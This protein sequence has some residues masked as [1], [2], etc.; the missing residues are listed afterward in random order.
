VLQ[1]PVVMEV[2]VAAGLVDLGVKHVGG[3]RRAAGAAAPAAAVARANGPAAAAAAGA[4]CRGGRLLGRRVC[5]RCRAGKRSGFYGCRNSELTAKHIAHA[6]ARPCTAAS[7]PGRTTAACI[8]P[9]DPPPTCAVACS[10]AAAKSHAA[11]PELYRSANTR[12]PLL[13]DT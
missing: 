8:S 1:H 4:C 2:H 5:G 6:R 13:G 11:C 3:R 10:Q 9:A 12:Y 7:Q